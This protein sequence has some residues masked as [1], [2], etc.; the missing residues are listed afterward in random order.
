MRAARQLSLAFV[1]AVSLVGCQ[2]GASNPAEPDPPGSPLTVAP[3]YA[4]LDGGQV[5]RLTATLAG[6]NHSRTAPDN[7]RWS[8]ADARIATVGQDGTVHALQAGRV[9]IV[10]EWQD[11]RG[12]S[13]IQVNEQISK[14][15][16]CLANLE[17][18]TASNG[19]SPCQ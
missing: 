4:R 10:A 17:G 14:K 12:S 18:S 13:L 8:S 7:V 2:S 1:A 11:S 5:I 15:G 9:Q 16:G 3:S 19:T 6:P